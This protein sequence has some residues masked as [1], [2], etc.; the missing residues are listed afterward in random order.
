MGPLEC[1]VD[2][3]RPMLPVYMSDVRRIYP[4]TPMDNGVA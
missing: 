2:G 3:S 4:D 1:V